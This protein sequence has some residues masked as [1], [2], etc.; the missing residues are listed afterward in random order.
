MASFENNLQ[1]ASQAILKRELTESERIE[2]LEL[3]GAIGMNSVEDYLYMLMIFKRNEDRIT[4]QM[5]SFR[6]EMKAR[7]DEMGFL[8]KKID[9]TLGKTLE[10][11]LGKGAEKIGYAMGRDIAHS[12][13]QVL[14]KNGEFHFLRGQVLTICVAA[15][16]GTIGYWL[17]GIDAF[18]IGEGRSFL[19]VFFWFPAGGFALICGIVYA[20][21]WYLD[22][23]GWITQY[24][25]F[26]QVYCAD[27][28]SSGASF[29]CASCFRMKGGPV[30]DR[31]VQTKRLPL[32]L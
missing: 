12:A 20:F 7:F 29:A 22:H 30:T 2:F 15:I 10:D 17:G 28:N 9:A 13:K 16:I 19:G 6:K 5:V 24:P 14:K 27:I 21:A 11:M 18:T 32:L 23:E 3:A 25:L 26:Y 31:I 4:G 1:A 8:E